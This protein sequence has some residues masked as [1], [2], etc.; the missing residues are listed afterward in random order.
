MSDSDWKNKIKGEV[1]LIVDDEADILNIY[2]YHIKN[3][4]FKV[5]RA[6]EPLSAMKMIEQNDIMLVITDHRMPNLDGT[7]FCDLI[8]ERFPSI[9]VVIISGYANLVT[10][11][12]DT[13]QYS[14]DLILNKPVD[15]DQFVDVVNSFAKK[16]YEKKKIAR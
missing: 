16:H 5:I 10:N 1:I 2:E 14:A 3:Q 13:C 6:M 7:N 11:T 12:S 15:F 8:K 9:P 4:G